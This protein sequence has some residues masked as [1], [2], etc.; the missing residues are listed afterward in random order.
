M[1]DFELSGWQIKYHEAWKEPFDLALQF[2]IL[3]RPSAL[4]PQSPCY[5]CSATLFALV[6]ELQNLQSLDEV[7]NA[8]SNPPISARTSSCLALPA[9][10]GYSALV[11]QLTTDITKGIKNI[12][13]FETFFN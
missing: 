6:M 3:S 13:P 10:C 9:T 7:Y 5:P 8:L 2:L 4:Y 1:I 11:K 12:P